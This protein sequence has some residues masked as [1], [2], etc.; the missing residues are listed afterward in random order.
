MNQGKNK[1]T[2]IMLGIIIVLVVAVIGLAAA[3]IVNKSGN[4]ES[5]T[6]TTENYATPEDAAT[7]TD[8][9][10][11]E[12]ADDAGDCYVTITN[13]NGWDSGDKYSG[14]LDAEIINN[15][16]KDLKNWSIEI[17]APD[18]VTIDSSWNGSF[19]AAD[20]TITITPVEYN[21][22]VTAGGRVSDIGFIVTVSDKSELDLM[23]ENARLY[24]D[25]E[26]YDS[27][28]SE[29]TTEDKQEESTSEQ[30]SSQVD[31]DGT[32]VSNHGRLS[33]SGT[34]LV[35]ENGDRY[36]LKGLSTHGLAWF[37]EYVNED[38][39]RTLR[40]DWGA[41]V[42]RLAMYTYESGG[43]CSDGDKDYLKG[44]VDTGVQSATELGM[45]VII[46]WH[47][48]QDTN[49]QTYKEEAK[50]FFEEMSAK[51]KDYD[52]VIYEICNEPNS[53]TSWS[54]VKSYAEE[55]IPI[56][57]NNAPEAIIIVGT[58]TWCQDVDVA[59]DDPITGYDNIMYAI[60]FYAATHTDSI[61]N[62]AI[63][64][65][66]SG[67]PV[68]VSEFSI[69]DASGNGAID[70]NQAD[71]WFNLIS[72]YNLS[73]VAWNISNKAET[74]SLIKS[75]CTKTS[76]WDVNDLS[77]TGVWIREKIKGNSQ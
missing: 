46:D 22:T 27:A 72:E 6:E 43:Y 64:A 47:V 25:G 12:D 17:D 11:A 55:V 59:A 14:Q 41:N 58:P 70:Y 40:D 39:F 56:I 36:Q 34:D 54:D 49:P 68:I 69:C 65:I 76:G 32:P 3:I 77:D 48:L 5:D 8:A 18:G 45:Y 30:E 31:E 33:V 67:L 16:D 29:D 21:N 13:T 63:A 9:D 7:I 38:A 28:A 10:E 4:S 44:L 50:K 26:L 53:G 71:E 75:S 15:S 73:Y 57:R 37:P 66:D 51:Y 62:K 35:D 74:S 42:I 19:E 1:T 2:K 52:N 60:H 23:T 24:I 61:R 20:G